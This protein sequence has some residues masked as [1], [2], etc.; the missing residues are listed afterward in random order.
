VIFNQNHTA[1]TNATIIALIN[2]AIPAVAQA[3]E[4]QVPQNEYYPS[5]PDREMLRSASG[6][7]GIT[8]FSA[9]V[10]VGATQV[11]AA[12]TAAL[13][14]DIVG[15]TLNRAVPG[16]QVRILRSGYLHRTPLGLPTF[17]AGTTVYL[18]DTNSGQV[19]LTGTRVFGTAIAQDWVQFGA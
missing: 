15:V 17:P 19:S 4:Y 12:T 5:F 16:A 7:N 2:A 9:V 11:N 6:P 3:V 8:R 10:A 1:Q 13:A 14:S 18:S